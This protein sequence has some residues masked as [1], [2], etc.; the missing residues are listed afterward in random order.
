MLL[1]DAFASRPDNI[2]QYFLVAV[3][4]VKLQ[5]WHSSWSI[6]IDEEVIVAFFNS[7]H[8]SFG[9]MRSDT[10]GFRRVRK[11]E[12]AATYLHAN[13]VVIGRQAQLLARFILETLHPNS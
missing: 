3:P 11:L 4:L 10:D 2:I 7:D 13:T 12:Q 8:P 9:V 5:S 6:L 1:D